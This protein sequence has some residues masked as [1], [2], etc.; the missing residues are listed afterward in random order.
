MMR[1]FVIALAGSLAVAP[2][3]AQQHPQGGAHQHPEA[4]KL[5]NP[6]P[7]DAA[8]IAAGKVV[9]EKNC[10][11]CHGATGAGDGKMGAELNPKPSNVADADWKHGASDGEIFTVIKSGVKGTGMKAFNSKLTEK[12]IWDVVNYIR[13]LG[14]TKS[15]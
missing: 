8:S 1:L 12:Q 6:A 14:P 2:A 15:H 13:T 9:Y 10:A 7:G 5:K 11:N 3:L 4:A